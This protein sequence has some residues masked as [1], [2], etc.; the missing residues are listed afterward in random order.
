MFPTCSAAV[1][2]RLSVP[3]PSP[4]AEGIGLEDGMI[5]LMLIDARAVAGVFCADAS[6]VLDALVSSGP[7]LAPCMPVGDDV[8]NAAIPCRM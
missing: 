7:A 3:I 4:A 2:L 1:E 6:G 8:L 5:S